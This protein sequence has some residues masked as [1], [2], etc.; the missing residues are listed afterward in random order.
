MPGE[1]GG[2]MAKKVKEHDLIAPLWSGSREVTLR[3]M[4]WQRVLLYY[5]ADHLH[6]RAGIGYHLKGRRVGPGI[7]S[8]TM[9]E[10]R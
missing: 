1:G 8:V 4:D 2:V 5:G 9:V 3:T 6:M 10:T 7:Y